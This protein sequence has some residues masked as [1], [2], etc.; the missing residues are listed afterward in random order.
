[1][2]DVPQRNPAVYRLL[3]ST[4]DFQLLHFG[5]DVV[6]LLRW[7]RGGSEG[8]H[9]VR[10]TA[11]WVGDP[12]WPKNEFPN[13]GV[14]LPVLSRRIADLMWGELEGAGKL[15]PVRIKDADDDYLLCLVERVADCLDREKSSPPDVIGRIKDSVFRADDIP[16]DVPAFRTTAFPTAVCWNGWAVRLLSG[17]LGEQLECRLVWSED[18]GLVPHHDPWGF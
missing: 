13:G 1:M 12:A 8:P 17:L 3:P 11:E 6:D 18:P 14:G 7:Q 4:A 2:S 5:D 15:L 9:P 16:V 10:F